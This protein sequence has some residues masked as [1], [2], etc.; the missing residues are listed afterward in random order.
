MLRI[1]LLRIWKGQSVLWSL[2]ALLACPFA[3]GAT[4]NFSGSGVSGT[5]NPDAL[6]WVLTPNDTGIG[7]SP[8]GISVWGTPGLSGGNDIWPAGNG[9]A[10]AFTITFSGLAGGITIDSSADPNPSGF[11]DFTRFHSNGDSVIWTPSV[12][13][14]TVTF[15]A[16]G[17]GSLTAGTPFFTNIAFSGGLVYTVTFSGMWTTSDVPEPGTLSLVGL[18]GICTV[19]VRR[20][21]CRDRKSL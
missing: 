11:D 3:Q 18:I 4:I 13:G 17:G 15:T 1:Q 9:A 20:S 21:L 16:P 10:I 12:G 7:I 8:R 5:I 14:N 2:A 19:V 6:P